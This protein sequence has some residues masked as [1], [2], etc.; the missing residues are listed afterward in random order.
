LEFWASPFAMR[1]KIALAEKGIEYESQEEDLMGGKSEL[2]LKSNPIYKKV[3]VLLH[4]GKPICESI[5]ILSYIEETW[6][7]PALLPECAYGKS[8]A[9]FWAD[10]ADKKVSS[11]FVPEFFTFAD[12]CY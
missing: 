12:L 9:R 2:L 3:P 5:I 8:V 10:Y 7:T 1:V 4:N 11:I 6:P